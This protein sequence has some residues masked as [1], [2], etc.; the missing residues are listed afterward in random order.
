MTKTKRSAIFLIRTFL[1]GTLKIKEVGMMILLK[2]FLSLFGLIAIIFSSIFLGIMVGNFLGWA[3]ILSIFLSC[4]TYIFLVIFFFLAPNN[5]FFTFVNEGTAKV[6]VKADKFEKALIQWEG[7]TFSYFDSG[8]DKWNVKEGSESHLFGGLR[9]YGFW[10]LWDIYGYGFEWSGINQQEKVVY[11]PKRTLD[12]VLLK[13]DVYWAGLDRAEDKNLLPLKV[14]LKLTVKIINPYRA[15]FRVQNW[16]E[17]LINRLKPEVRN[18]ITQKEYGEWITEISNMGDD[19]FTLCAGILDEFEKEY[20]IKVRKIQIKELDP[21]PEYRENTL[22][23]YLAEMR[24]RATVID[25]DAEVERIKRVFAT[26]RDFEDT[27]SLVRILEAMEK[28]PL[29]ASMVV[30]AIP[31]L[32]EALRKGLRSVSEE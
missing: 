17:T 27:G 10:P 12:Y 15:L 22:A 32:Q 23:P 18:F 5:L 11:H 28:S 3:I 19:I 21:P 2:I 29:P 20:G 13:E 14:E 25:A 24:K 8:D 30:Q 6:I 1:V 26:I 7:R 9:F 16:L 4:P 31:G